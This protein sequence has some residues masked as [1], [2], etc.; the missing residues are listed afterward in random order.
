MQ[1]QKIWQRIHTTAEQMNETTTS[2]SYLARRKSF[3]LQRLRV[4][5]GPH[6]VEFF[7]CFSVYLEESISSVLGDQL[8]FATTNHHHN[9]TTF[10]RNS[11]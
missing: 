6:D 10:P 5:G 2:D 3:N 8:T 4:K 9:R 1:S 7:K 11:L